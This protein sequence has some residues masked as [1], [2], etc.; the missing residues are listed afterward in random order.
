MESR[1]IV[2]RN[3]EGE[4]KSTEAEYPDSDR[5]GWQ[6][7]MEDIKNNQTSLESLTVMKIRNPNPLVTFFST[8]LKQNKVLTSL[9]LS[10]C[11][12]KS[13]LLFQ[14][15]EALKSNKSIT[16]LDISKNQIW[17]PGMKNLSGV[18]RLNQ[19]IEILNLSS[20]NVGVTSWKSFCE[21]LEVNR[22]LT[23]LNLNNNELGKAAAIL[24]LSLRKNQYLWSISLSENNLEATEIN[25]LCDS[26]VEHPLLAHIDISK[27]RIK[28]ESA[29]KI[30][31]AIRLTQNLTSID[32]SYSKFNEEGF[33]V[34]CEAVEASELKEFNFRQSRMSQKW[35]KLLEKL[36]DENHHVLYSNTDE[37]RVCLYYLTGDY[38]SYY[39]EPQTTKV[40][41]DRNCAAAKVRNQQ[42]VRALMVL[43]S[44]S[45]NISSCSW[46]N[47]LPPELHE[48]IFGVLCFHSFES[49]GKTPVQIKLCA[50]FIQQHMQLIK[51]RLQEG[52]QFTI[53]ETLRQFKI[54]FHDEE[55]I[56]AHN[57][58]VQGLKPCLANNLL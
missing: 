50:K 46:W 33:R 13:H 8:N 37:E 1:F 56:R 23:Q 31:S 42:L 36:F 2:K 35:W 30:A 49:V 22:S 11:G 51:E 4:I 3:N 41:L 47:S 27:N 32:L 45:L 48:Y 5:N 19:T 38:D 10:F 21:S 40:F 57:P 17:G 58:E 16:K 29:Q 25:Q 20:N 26:F 43:Q 34:I 55:A 15:A 9:T 24:S 18:L 6:T 44:D 7:F 39:M 54:T 12:I 14:L 53:I 52:F 28:D